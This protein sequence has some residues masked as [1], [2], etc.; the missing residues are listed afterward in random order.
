LV[1]LNKYT[2]LPVLKPSLEFIKL[3]ALYILLA[4][5]G[6]TIM[7]SIEP[8]TWGELVIAAITCVCLSLLITWPMLLQ[9]E[10]KQKLVGMF[11]EKG[12]TNV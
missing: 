7:Q 6:I 9:K 12:E 8:L 1:L 4:G 5:L 2:E 10:V 3:A 11:F